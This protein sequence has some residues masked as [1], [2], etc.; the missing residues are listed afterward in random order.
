MSS[1][2]ERD[3]FRA[4]VLSGAALVASVPGCGESTTP[5]DAATSGGDSGD[6]AAVLVAD[7]GTD[8]AAAEDA[9]APDDANEDAFV[10]I[11]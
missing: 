8:A 4:I 9:G 10:V 7:A 11:L 6:D 3:L 2:H 5:S 1:A